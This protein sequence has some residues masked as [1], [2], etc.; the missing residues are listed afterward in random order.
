M[1]CNNKQFSFGTKAETLER[2]DCLLKHS[3][4][5]K[6]CYFPV[7]RWQDNKEQVLNKI[8]P[9][10]SRHKVIIRSSAYS[11]DTACLAM[12]GLYESIPDVFAKDKQSLSRAI[13][14][15]IASYSKADRQSKGQDQVLVQLMIED[16]SMSGVLFTQDLNTGA[17][18][19]VINYDDESGRT[20]TITAGT[21]NSNRTL[22]VHRNSVDQLGSERFKALLTAV[23]EI[24]EITASDSLDIEF[25]LDKENNVYILQVRRITTAPNWNRRIVQGIDDAMLRLQ[26]FVRSAF[27]PK[28]S[29]RGIRTIF[30]RMPDWNPAEM[31]GTAPRPLAISLYRYLITD[32]AWRQAR[33][34]MGYFEPV[35]SRLMV[36]LHGQPYID[37]RLSL[38]SFLPADLEPAIGEKLVNA[39]LN[40]LSEH[41]E[42]H[43]KIEFEIAITTLAFDFDE[44][45]KAQIP[46]V[47][48]EK[49]LKEFR[50]R[51]FKLTD[52]LLSARKASIKVELDK[53]NT[54]QERRHNIL[55]D[56]KHPDL[57][58]VQ[59]LLEDCIRFGT[60]PFSVLARHAFIAKSFLRSFVRC[61]IASE[62]EISAFQRSIKTVAGEVVDDFDR[63]SMGDISS[64]EF[65]AKY[66]H[67]RPGTYD[68]LS[69][70]YDQRDDLVNGQV[71]K[72]L[73]VHKKEEFSFSRQ[74]IDKI[75]Q[76]LKRFGFSVNAGQ[77]IDYIKESVAA[78]EYAKF[79][80]TK[81]ISDALEI[82]TLWGKDTGLTRE[83]LSYIPIEAILN[84]VTL[85][86][87]KTLQQ[88]LRDISAYEK[89]KHQITLVLHLPYL[90]DILSDV[91]I[92]PLLLNRPNFITKNSVKGAYIFLDAKNQSLPDINGQIVLIEGADPGFDWIFSRP[93]SGLITKYGGANSHMAIRC[94]EFGIPAAIGCGEQIFDRILH[95]REIELNCAEG[96][97]VPIEG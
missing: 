42:L 35:G 69:R 70:R 19:Y 21:Q 65:M 34:Q 80:F 37:V 60:I 73:H 20:D 77:L 45:V 16:V 43:D 23:R 29:L 92:V 31:I 93:I 13:D 47:L 75:D 51:L 22:L 1:I 33:R 67:L 6:F 74:Q 55:K 94:A 81:N 72:P 4:I 56:C 95:S 11:E 44:S 2:L 83:E 53:I 89:D 25:A 54:L 5:P 79:I 26:E 62:A 91:V 84:A 27:K 96:K 86:E 39:W 18:Y 66:G 36:S 30:G 38:N 7:S 48:T 87:G 40:R 8:Q 50:D 10:F 57:A 82:I 17:P 71:K 97:I 78:R 3:S 52:N 90:I 15:V 46:G 32:F 85:S 24:E 28:A 61:A 9:D 59:G 76:L 88:Y 14:S 68:I 64:G 58:A 41:K 49:E 12:A 63:L